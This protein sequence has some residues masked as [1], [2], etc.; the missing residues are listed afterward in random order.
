VIRIPQNGIYCNYAVTVG[1][2]GDDGSALQFAIFDIFISYFGFGEISGQFGTLLKL[3][4]VGSLFLGDP[5]RSKW[6]IL[7]TQQELVL[8]EALY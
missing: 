5:D 6:H 3:K 2:G 1:A 4:G 8:M 7:I